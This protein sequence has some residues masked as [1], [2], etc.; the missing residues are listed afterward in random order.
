MFDIIKIVDDSRANVKTRRVV[1]VGKL[2]PGLAKIEVVASFATV[3]D[4]EEIE[5][6]KSA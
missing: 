5:N 1:A 6:A 2:G 4:G 3:V